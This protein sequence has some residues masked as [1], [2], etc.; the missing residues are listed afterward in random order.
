MAKIDSR[1]YVNICLFQI[2]FARGLTWH[3]GRKFTSN[4][5][6]YFDSEKCN[7]GETCVDDRESDLGEKTG[8]NSHQMASMENT[9]ADLI[10]RQNGLC[11][12]L[13]DSSGSLSTSQH[14][15]SSYNSIS[16]PD[17]V[18]YPILK[19]LN[20]ALILICSVCICQA[21]LFILFQ[22]LVP[23]PFNL[24]SPYRPLIWTW[25]WHNWATPWNI[26]KLYL[27]ATEP[28]SCH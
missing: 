3:N 13:K 19:W 10:P 15:L 9:S 20:T 5:K 2:N 12:T 26:W 28:C 27:P 25:A 24:L 6:V 4:W 23:C 14:G 22:D 21:C 7:A 8:D 11:P 16:T 1:E 18:Q 17:M